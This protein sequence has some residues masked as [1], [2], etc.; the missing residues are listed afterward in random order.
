VSKAL[1]HGYDNVMIARIEGGGNQVCQVEW[2]VRHEQERYVKK[3]FKKTQWMISEARARAS[4]VLPIDAPQ[5]IQSKLFIVFTLFEF[6]FSFFSNR[7]N[8]A[9]V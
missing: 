8:L 1:E 9:L 3:D 2:Q 5:S 6:F 4:V 7:N